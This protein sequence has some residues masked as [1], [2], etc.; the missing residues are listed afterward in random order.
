MKKRINR[1]IFSY[2]V[3]IC[4]IIAFMITIY[5]LFT[6]SR[7]SQ[8]ASTAA[9]YD[10]MNM[11]FM[12]SYLQDTDAVLNTADTLDKGILSVKNPNKREA[13]STIYLYISEDA[14]LENIE[15]IID[16][17]KIDTTNATVSDGY[18]V[19]PALNCEIDAFQYKYIDTEIKGNAFNTTPFSYKFGVE[20]F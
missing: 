1:A 12:L 4:V 7:I 16:G 3:Q 19:L 9:A 17:N 20:S 13:S 18:Y 8:Y 6:N 15:F 2:V 14:N 5:Y 11:D 10:T